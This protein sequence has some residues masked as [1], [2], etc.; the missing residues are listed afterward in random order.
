MMS[1]MQPLLLSQF[2]V[3]VVESLFNRLIARS[4][5]CLPILRKLADKTLH[6]SLKQ[7]DLS[8]FIVFSQT[9]T[10]WLSDYEG[11]TDCAV[12]LD[13]FALPKLADKS[14]LSGLINDKTLILQGDLAVIQQFSALLDELDKNPAELLSDFIG[15]VPAQLSTDLASKVWQKISRQFHQDRQHLIEN[16]MLERPV[17][18]HRLQAVDFYDQIDELAQQAVGLEQKFAKLGIK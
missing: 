5:Q 18:V 16:L 6:I 12:Q 17:L 4:E 9:R 7:P 10:D 15:D 13:A 3:G 8:F 1:P 11:E 2:G 14:K